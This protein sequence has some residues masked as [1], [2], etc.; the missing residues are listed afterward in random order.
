MLI[1]LGRDPLF[2]K[3]ARADAIYGLVSL[4]DEA[5]GSPSKLNKL[6]LMLLY[7]GND[8]IIP[9]GP[10]EQVLAKLGPNATVKRY[11]NG[12]HMLLRDLAGGERWADI[13]LWVA[14]QA[15]NRRGPPMAMAAE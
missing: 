12:Y 10:T 15:R 2:Q 14:A 7:G 6:P 13:S 9:K 8:Q 1:A 3:R 5:Y 11:P 4:M